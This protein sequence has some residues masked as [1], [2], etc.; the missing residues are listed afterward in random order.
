MNEEGYLLAQGHL[1][2]LTKPHPSVKLDI[3][4]E[5]FDLGRVLPLTSRY[6]VRLYQGRLSTD[7]SV[8][9]AR[10]ASWSNSVTS[11]SSTRL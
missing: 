4:V 3:R 5:N 1:D 11:Q 6:H 7:G 10:G 8:E 9:Y 2:V